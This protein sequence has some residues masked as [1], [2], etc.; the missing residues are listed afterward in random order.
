MKAILR[1]RNWKDFQHYKDRNPPWIKL[2]YEL[3]TSKDWVKLSDASRLLAVVCMM[4]ASRN[5]GQI[6]ADEEYVQKVAHLDAVP[7]FNPLIRCNFLEVVA[8]ASTMQADAIIE[9]RREETEERREERPET[10]K[11]PKENQEQT[12]AKGNVND[13]DNVNAKE[14][15]LEEKLRYGLGG[16]RPKIGNAKA[17]AEA[18]TPEEFLKAMG[19][20]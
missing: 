16:R 2:H 7:D 9:K 17:M 3:I 20:E 4:L 13:N 19:I 5:N 12:Q 18:A 1:V 8:D 6:E 15:S 10:E 11:E 14:G